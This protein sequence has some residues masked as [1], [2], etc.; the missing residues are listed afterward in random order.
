MVTNQKTKKRGEVTIIIR[1][2]P[3]FTFEDLMKL[4]GKTKL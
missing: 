3:L 4:Q 1:Q 2:Q